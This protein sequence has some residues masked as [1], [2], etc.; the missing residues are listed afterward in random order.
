MPIFGLKIPGPVICLLAISLLSGCASMTPSP[1][2]GESLA[3]DYQRMLLESEG[4]LIEPSDSTLK[5]HWRGQPN[6]G[7]LRKHYARRK[8][9]HQRCELNRPDGEFAQAMED[10]RPGA[11]GE[12]MRDW[13]ESCPVDAQ[14]HLYAALA[15]EEAGLGIAS[16]LHMDWFLEITDRALATGDGRSADTAFETI[17]IQESHALLLRLGLHGVERELIR[18]GQ[19]IDRVIAED[20]SGQR[21]TLYFHP[22]WHFIRLHARVAAQQAESP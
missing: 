1:T 22:R 16:R 8:D 11:A 12:L 14:G 2:P 21:H 10:G 9:F 3:G 13:L 4:E 6:A 20:S 7:D 15:Y 17:S 18:D 5:A 19:L